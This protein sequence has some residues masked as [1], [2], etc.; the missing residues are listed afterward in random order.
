[1][2]DPGVSGTPAPETPG[3]DFLGRLRFAFSFSTVEVQRRT[4][5]AKMR[6]KFLDYFR[7]T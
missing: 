6:G 1:M 5:P 4:T 3:W 7:L 2:F